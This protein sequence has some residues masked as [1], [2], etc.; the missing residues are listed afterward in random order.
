MTRLSDGNESRNFTHSPRARYTLS[1]NRRLLLGVFAVFLTVGAA[2]AILPLSGSEPS[3]E[4]ATAAKSDIAAEAAPATAGV[5]LTPQQIAAGGIM[6]EKLEPRPLPRVIRAPGEVKAN[7]YTANLVSPR[8]TATVVAR[9]ARLGERVSKGQP[10]VTLFS[11]DVAEAQS[12]YVLAEQE[13]AR[14][15][16][17]GRDI[18]AGQQYDAAV[19]K[20]QEA[21]GR[22]ESYGVTPTDM[23]ALDGQGLGGG[24]V[25]QFD[26]AAAQAGI[27]IT[28]DFRIGEVIDAGKTL[29]EIADPSVVW[30]EARVSPE[31][32]AEIAGQTGKITAGEWTR[33][34][35]MLQV[36]DVL[37]E[38]TRTIGVR[39]EVRNQDRKLKPGQFVDV[40]LYGRAQ[41]VLALP[42]ESVLRNPDG[43][44][45]VFLETG[46]G[47]FQS[48]E[49]EV[50]YAAGDLTVIS[51]LEAGSRVVTKGA[52][53]IMSEAA[54][55]GFDAHA[56]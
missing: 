38:A 14:L 44:W 56:H 46:P 30:V 41:S 16:R 42:T 39:L 12:A 11:V 32:A 27:I 9:H 4:K 18:V 26:L 37:D 52:F 49:V 31:L 23:A 5:T 29:F 50:S 6:V 33:E 25:G 36:R 21:R 45:A 1:R 13:F 54:K 17:V 22:L 24:K 43:D 48:K 15:E 19:I 53:S 47:T 8:I 51:G 55:A 10:L 7:E 20:R 40:E 28:D 3:T 35:R 2:A 34:A